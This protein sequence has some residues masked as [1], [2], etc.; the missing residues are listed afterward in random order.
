MILLLAGTADAGEV[1]AVAKEAGYRVVASAV[2]EYGS[3]LTGQRGADACTVGPQDEAGLNLLIR[4]H[5]VRAVV[6][7]THPF[8][9][10][11]S[12][13]ATKVCNQLGILYI[14]LERA[15]ARWTGE[16]T[17]IPVENFFEAGQKATDLGKVIFS[18]LGSKHIS[19]LWEAAQEKECRLIAR[20][21]PEPGAINTCLN[22]G[23]PPRDVVAMQG[24]F[25]HELNKAL[26]TQYG[27]NVIVSKESGYTGG[28]DTK[29]S[30]AREL[31]IPLVLIRRP[32]IT[33]PL[34]VARAEE[35]VPLLI[36]K[37]IHPLP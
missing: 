31:G 20:V 21:L 27:A 1:L 26:F 14:R 7:A 15:E 19:V 32:S 18:T 5:R 13:L 2:S 36:E 25:S 3:L 16:T 34:Q 37:G 33:Y 22:L 8:A 35:V 24:P 4:D 12:G 23:M 11:I 10:N 28:T 6:D 9:V 29:I 17:V 30:A